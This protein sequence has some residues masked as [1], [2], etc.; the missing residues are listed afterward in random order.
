MRYQP[1]YIANGALR[2]F[3]D[4]ERLSLDDINGKIYARSSD[5]IIL[6]GTII[7]GYG[8]RRSDFDV[9]VI[10]DRRPAMADVDPSR[11]HWLYRGEDNN[12]V[13]TDRNGELYQLFDYLPN[14]NYAWDVE[15][16]TLD[17]VRKVI[18][19][20]K[21]AHASLMVHGFRAGRLSPRQAE[22][23][24]KGLRGLRL[25]S[26]SAFE[27]VFGELS[28]PE[29]CY[30]LYRQYAG[31]YPVIRDIQGAWL[32]QEYDLAIY[33]AWSHLVDQLMSLTFLEQITNH[34]VKWIYKKVEALS[35]ESAAV[36]ERFHELCSPDLRDEQKK[37]E[38]VLA[39]LDLIDL[40]YD[41]CRVLLD[42]NAAFQSTAEGIRITEQD[43]SSRAADNPEFR[44]QLEYRM[45]IYR[46]GGPT[47]RALV[48]DGC[49]D[50]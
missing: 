26:N 32:A 21:N 39:I 31:G 20:V 33:S 24:H 6:A 45:K 17:E 44:R 36:R 40:V 41:R 4:E 10:C 27:A 30:V 42:S 23:L 34:N 14:G 50:V 5:A 18:G 38:H 16:W 48:T 2:F 25:Q 22:F 12:S 46:A 3:N 43:E 9:Y 28:V 49:R 15:Y 13:T 1:A 11:H 19:A 7:E 47:C 8:N 35:D 37:R 29:F